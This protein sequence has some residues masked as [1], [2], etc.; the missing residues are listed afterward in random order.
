[1][2]TSA[3]YIPLTSMIM[4]LIGFFLLVIVAIFVA[5]KFFHRHVKVD[6]VS[7]RIARGTRTQSRYDRPHQPKFPMFMVLDHTYESNLLR[8]DDQRD[9]GAKLAES[10]EIERERWLNYMLLARLYSPNNN[11]YLM[12]DYNLPYWPN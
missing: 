5:F 1:M 7:K 3:S 2:A 11:V 12:N 4:S 8:Y 9:Q 6:S 10:Q